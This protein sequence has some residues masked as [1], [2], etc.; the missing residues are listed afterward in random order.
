MFVNSGASR[1]M[2]GNHDH[3]S[4][5]DEKNIAQRFEL[6]YNG[7]Y[8]VKGVGSSSFQL[9]SGGNVSI[10]NILYVLDLKKKLL[11]ISS[12]EDKGY[13]INFVDRQVLVWKKDASF[14]YAKVIGVR[15]GGLYRLPKAWTFNSRPTT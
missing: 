5:L 1:H 14:E 10:N 9:Y 8:E 4:K 11:S 7:K 15:I 6:G 13:R 12:F 2:T 3:L